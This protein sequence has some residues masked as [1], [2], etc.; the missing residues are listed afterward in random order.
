MKRFCPH[1]RA[2]HHTA[3]PRRPEH[4]PLGHAGDS[5]QLV[6]VDPIRLPRAA[7][8]QGRPKPHGLAISRMAQVFLASD[9]TGNRVID[10]RSG[11]ITG[12]IPIG[13]DPSDDAHQ[14]RPL[15]LRPLPR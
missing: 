1:S 12:Q 8:D 14:R 5:D 11:R 3:L 6:E 15:R 10:A 4:Q 13:N 7:P 2:S 9:K